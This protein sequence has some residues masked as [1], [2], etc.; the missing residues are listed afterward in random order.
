M[1]TLLTALTNVMAFV[2]LTGPMVALAQYD[3]QLIEYPVTPD[4]QV[5]GINDRGDVVG[6][7]WPDEAAG[8]PFVYSPNKDTFTDVIPA[9]GYAETSTSGISDSG[10]MVGSVLSLDFSTFSGFIRETNGSF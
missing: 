8:Y 10:V 7:G 4:T 2:L 3:Y 1:K 5:F 6:T 9:A